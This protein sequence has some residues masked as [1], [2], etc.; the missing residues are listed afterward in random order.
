MHVLSVNAWLHPAVDRDESNQHAFLPHQSPL[1]FSG[2]FFNGPAEDRGT[3]LRFSLGSSRGGRM[4]GRSPVDGPGTH[5]GHGIVMTPSMQIQNIAVRSDVRSVDAL[6]T[7]VQVHW[8]QCTAGHGVP[9]YEGDLRSCTTVRITPLT[10]R[11]S[12][13]SSGVDHAFV[14]GKCTIWTKLH[15]EAVVLVGADLGGDQFR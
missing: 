14:Q 7:T 11:C 15:R 6:P 4:M 10:R 13:P 12:R 1:A 3:R 5:R 8:T 9:A 2:I